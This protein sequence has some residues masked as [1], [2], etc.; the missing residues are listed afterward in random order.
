MTGG[1]SL[2]KDVEIKQIL[3]I[4]R[5]NS[6][7]ETRSADEQQSFL[8]VSVHLTTVYNYFKSL[9]QNSNLRR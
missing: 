4:F 9:A 5:R 1:A 8:C 6:G 7:C 3:K 2:V